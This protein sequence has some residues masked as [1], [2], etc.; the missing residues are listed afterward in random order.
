M[1]TKL[2]MRLLAAAV[3]VSGCTIAHQPSLDVTA[4]AYVLP[5][6]PRLGEAVKLANAQADE[7]VASPA[8]SYTF[9]ADLRQYTEAV[10][11]SLQ[12][13]LTRNGFPV[14]PDAPKTLQVAVVDVEMVFAKGFRCDLNLTLKMGDDVVGI[15]TQSASSNYYPEAIDAALADAVRRIMTHA[16]VLAFLAGG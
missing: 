4:A 14:D 13:E 6:M 7:V 15:A 8:S 12:R 9:E 11:A 1:R 5:S 10:L 16:K 3:L 2:S